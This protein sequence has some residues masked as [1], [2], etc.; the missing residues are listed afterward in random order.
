M[1]DKIW[2]NDWHLKYPSLLLQLHFFKR[3]KNQKR[4][5]SFHMFHETHFISIETIQVVNYL[6]LF[7]SQID[8]SID[9]LKFVSCNSHIEIYPLIK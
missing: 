4:S 3:K 7:F 2:F 6:K 8:I 9:V 5:Y 1:K